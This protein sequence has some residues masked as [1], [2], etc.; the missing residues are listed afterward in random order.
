MNYYH[1]VTAYVVACH[2]GPLYGYFSRHLKSA[3]YLFNS[4]FYPAFLPKRIQG[5]LCSHTSLTI[6]GSFFSL[7]KQENQEISPVLHHAEAGRCTLHMMVGSPIGKPE[8]GTVREIFFNFT[9]A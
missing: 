1:V 6:V 7:S 4:I 2:S 9:C 8:Q 5:G 3:Y